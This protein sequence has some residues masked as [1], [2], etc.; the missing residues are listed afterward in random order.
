[1][2]I[3]K[4]E[5]LIDIFFGTSRLIRKRISDCGTGLDHLS[6]LRLHALG[7]IA[8]N[9]PTVSELGSF[10]KISRPSATSMIKSLVEQKFVRKIKEKS[11]GRSSRLVILPGGQ[12][13]IKNGQAKI[14]ANLKPIL[15]QLTDREL[16]NFISI[17]KHLQIIAASN[18]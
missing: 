17:Y 7:Y 8:E 1:M 4:I 16:E 13:F 5:T 14:V 18:H 15:S 9:K 3:N 6:W 10:L 2:K 11:D 12:K